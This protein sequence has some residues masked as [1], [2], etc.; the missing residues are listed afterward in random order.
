MVVGGGCLPPEG[1]GQRQWSLWVPLGTV[2][3]AHLQV[4]GSLVCWGFK[5]TSFDIRDLC[6]NSA[7]ARQRSDLPSLSLSLLLC[8]SVETAP[9]AE[10]ARSPLEP[11][12]HLRDHIAASGS[13]SHCSWGLCGPHH[14]ISQKW[15]WRS[16]SLMESCSYPHAQ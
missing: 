1:S 3:L 4:P 13:T 9:S 8:K 14:P 12:V 5:G 7:A 2:L 11:A 6:S 10:Q 16:P 15:R